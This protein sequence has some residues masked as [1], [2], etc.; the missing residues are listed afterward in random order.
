MLVHICCSVDSHYFLSELKKALPDTKFT[1]F[2]YNPN[3]HPKEEHDLRYLDVKRSCEMLDIPLILG[4]YETDF[5][6][7]DVVGL[8]DEPEKGER[9]IK[10]F[11]IR[12][13]RTAIEAQKIGEKEF[14]STLLSSPMKE[15][16]ILYK[17]GDE[18]GSGY[19]L[20]FF[21]INVRANGGV[22][23]QNELAKKDKLYRQ[24]YCG[25]IFALSKQ[26]AHQGKVSLE[27]MS[28][29]ASGN[30]L[31]SISERLEVF[32]ER[33]NVEVDSKN[34]DRY[35]LTQRAHS[36]Y[37][38]TTGLLE[39]NGEGIP[40]Y[41]LSNS[42]KK[43]VKIKDLSWFK[44]KLDLEGLMEFEA[45][46]EGDFTFGFS[47][48]DDSIFVHLNFI[49]ALFGREFRNTLELCRGKLKLTE[50]MLLRR[51]LCGEGSINPIII[52]DAPFEACELTIEAFF[53]DEKLFR[54]V[55]KL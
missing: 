45:Y 22:N 20:E 32:E 2:F 46:I 8:E 36:V 1:G 14:T 55:E 38:I 18:V 30:E 9:C 4:E 33:D 23:R 19:G 31:G 41:I 50:E 28:S 42:Q 5:W 17:K 12:L 34:H 29:F 16:E 24:N 47:S 7:R 48:K 13:L 37:R 49:N 39:S 53:Q 51:L 11:D 25:C 43:K 40:S 26:R 35:M 27:M 15:Q 54:V 21:K 10:C 6:F 52:V 44:P 3:I